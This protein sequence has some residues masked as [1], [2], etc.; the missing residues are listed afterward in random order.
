MESGMVAGTNTVKTSIALKA[1][2]VSG[3]MKKN[4]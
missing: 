4:G 3:G 2:I 1:G